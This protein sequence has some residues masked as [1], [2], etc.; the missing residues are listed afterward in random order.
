MIGE[1]SLSRLR[2]GL[3]WVA[4]DVRHGVR[5]LSR[6]PSFFLTAVLSL[7]LGIG[8][9]I[10]VFALLNS[11]V[12]RQLPV[13]EPDELVTMSRSDQGRTS[14][15]VLSLGAIRELTTDSTVLESVF[16]WF[17]QPLS[18]WSGDGDAQWVSGEVVTAQYFSTLNVGALLGRVLNQDDVLGATGDPVC[19][20]S[21]SF[22]QRAFGQDP[23]I[24]GQRIFLNGTPY[25]VIG[26]TPSDFHGAVLHRRFDVIVP[27]TRI[28][29]FL[30]AFSGPAGV[31]RLGTVSW[32]TSMARLAPGVPRADAQRQV[33][34]TLQRLNPDR[35][36][37][38]VLEDG[39][40]GF[41]SMRQAFDR[42][43]AILAVAAL[44]VFVVSCVN[45]ANLT[46]V[47]GQSRMRELASRLAL[48]ASRLRLVS[49]LLVESALLAVAGGLLGCLL[50]IWIANVIVSMLNLGQP[51]TSESSVA[52]DPLVLGFSLAVT[53]AAALASGG[54]PAWRSASV[55]A[56]RGYHSGVNVYRHPTAGVTARAVLVAAQFALSLAVVVGAGLLVRTIYEMSS[57]DLGFDPDS[58]VAVSLDP[59]AS[60]YSSVEALRLIGELAES[61]NA[62][63]GVVAASFASSIPGDTTS[64]TVRFEVPGYVPGSVPGDDVT[65]VTLVSPLYFETLGLE[66]RSGRYF[67]E[68]DEASEMPV[69]LVNERFAQRY[70]GDQSPV[71]REI[72]QGE[73]RFVVIGVVEDA[74]TAGPR[75]D[76]IGSV[77][78]L[79]SQGPPLGMTLLVRV[80]DNPERV[81][82]RVTDLVTAFDNQI[83]VFSTSTLSERLGRAFAT[84]RML[85]WF[86]VMFASL[87]TLLSGVGLYGVLAHS[88]TQREREIGIRLAVGAQRRQVAA[89]FAGES[90][91]ILI[92][93]I[94]VGGPVALFFATALRRILFGVAATDVRIFVVSAVM[95]VVV[96]SAATII[97]VMRALG[98]PPSSTLLSE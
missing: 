17:S 28:G 59:Q 34:S 11:V 88:V 71:G 48:G 74:R 89:M 13:L 69:A 82:A 41:D 62:L 94:V 78:I 76:A 91:R 96:A 20:V 10:A 42:P 97:P 53:V 44:L 72:R 86:L 77:Y 26:V 65:S 37:V 2:E 56:T 63:D 85:G 18:Y 36:G 90:A 70:F 27:A 43:L 75:N 24:V 93:G 47:R 54:L 33:Q 5:A 31:E 73:S 4:Q 58:V 98:V 15:E 61:A 80:L 39:R 22:W 55:A 3:L 60:G 21:Y 87:A 81:M 52:L 57:V 66:L 51:A 19:V 7:A 83:P 32:L 45:V 40:Q 9:N 35:D 16:G 8:V 68:Q 23:E 38:V 14:P 64:L 95:L 84:E 79:A 12:I 46:I 49:Q 6:R 92:S 67:L 1:T 29:D 30:P 25:R 50:S